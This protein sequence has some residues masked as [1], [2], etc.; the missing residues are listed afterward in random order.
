MHS[1]VGAP[2]V[3][4]FCEKQIPYINV[5]NV[6]RTFL[7]YQIYHLLPQTNVRL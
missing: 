6:T 5:E 1:L 4:V 3:R 2:Q 7:L